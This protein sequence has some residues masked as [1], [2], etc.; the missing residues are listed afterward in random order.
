MCRVIEYV[1]IFSNA[2][3]SFIR[4]WYSFSCSQAEITKVSLL[5]HVCGYNIR[6]VIVQC[7]R[8][9]FSFLRLVY[10]RTYYIDAPVASARWFR[11]LV[12]I[13]PYFALFK[14]FSD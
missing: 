11:S 9:F 4:Y 12:S 10:D 14:L 5:W 1:N 3:T 8:L 2:Y 13:V 7:N 6:S